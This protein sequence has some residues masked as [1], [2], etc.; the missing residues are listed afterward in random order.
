MNFHGVCK[1]CYIGANNII[2]MAFIK[3]ILIIEAKTFSEP[4][5]NLHNNK[6]PNR[7]S[8]LTFKYEKRNSR[9]MDLFYFQVIFFIYF[10]ITC[11]WL[12]CSRPKIVFAAL[13][14][15]N[16]LNDKTFPTCSTLEIL[17]CSTI[18][19]RLWR[20]SLQTTIEWD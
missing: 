6:K 10:S 18:E 4:Y 3:T 17:Q 19:H 20:Q 8:S 14:F 1:C 5:T 13:W 7:E 15:M 12:F 2:S 9:F 11:F 16:P